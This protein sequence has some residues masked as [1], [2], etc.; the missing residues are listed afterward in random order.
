MCRLS[1]SATFL[2]VLDITRIGH[3]LVPNTLTFKTRPSAKPFYVKMR[4]ICMRNKSYYHIKD[5]ALS[6]VLINRPKATRKWPIVNTVL[7]MGGGGGGGKVP[8]KS[9]PYTGKRS[10]HGGFW[11][12]K[13]K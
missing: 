13:Q 12:E 6:L 3:F 11:G 2:T 10:P 1:Y 8:R 9:V 7:H 5:F 4:F